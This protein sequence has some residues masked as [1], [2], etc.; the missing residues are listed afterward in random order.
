MTV[1]IGGCSVAF[2]ITHVLTWGSSYASVESNSDD[3]F[4]KPTPDIWLTVSVA[5]ERSLSDA[6][7]LDNGGG[8]RAGIRCCRPYGVEHFLVCTLSDASMPDSGGGLREGTGSFCPGP[9]RS[10]VEPSLLC[11]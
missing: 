3:D 10:G 8:C 11:S 7:M 1:S 5:A 2:L 9:G 4:I 6:S